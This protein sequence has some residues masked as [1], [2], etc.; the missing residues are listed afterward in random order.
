MSIYYHVLIT[1]PG[2]TDSF[3][4]ESHVNRSEMAHRVKACA[5]LGTMRRVGREATQKM[6]RYIPVQ[7]MTTN[8]EHESA[9]LAWDSRRTNDLF[10]SKT[11]LVHKLNKFINLSFI[12]DWKK[13]R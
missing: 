13:T 5:L 12:H 1:S 8:L 3:P 9:T 11:T 4:K 10:F 7:I 2:T 6:D